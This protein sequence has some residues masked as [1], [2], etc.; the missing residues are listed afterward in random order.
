MFDSVLHTPLNTSKSMLL[1]PDVFFLLGTNSRSIHPEVSL[2]KDVL[3]ICS[4]FT[5]ECPC[6]SVISIKLQN[7][8]IE[9]TLWHGYSPVNLLHIFGTPFAKDTSGGLL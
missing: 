3:K 7:N 1:K 8:F 2:V 5:G 4:K 6:Q 9:I